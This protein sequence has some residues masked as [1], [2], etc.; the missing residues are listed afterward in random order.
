MKQLTLLAA[1]LFSTPIFG[2]AWVPIGAKWVY[3][4]DPFWMPGSTMDFPATCTDTVD[5]GGKFYSKIEFGPCCTSG[6]FASPVFLR[7]DS[8][9]V[10]FHENGADKLLY[11]FNTPLFGSWKVEVPW[12]GGPLEIFVVG[13]DTLTYFGVKKRVFL[14]QYDNMPGDWGSYV[15]EGIGSTYFLVPQGPTCDPQVYGMQCFYNPLL[16][17]YGS[18]NCI[19]PTENLIAEKAGFEASPNPSFGKFIIDNQQ[20]AA[21]SLLEIFSFS[22]N[23]IREFHDPPRHFEVDLGSEPAGIFFAKWTLPDGHFFTKKLILK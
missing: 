11:D 7:A 13:V 2:Q 20:V 8:N 1:F 17:N 23:T 16:G 21:N 6:G 9:R 12:G 10:F 4:L 5:I 15:V 14:L 3:S 22:G 19:V 18:T